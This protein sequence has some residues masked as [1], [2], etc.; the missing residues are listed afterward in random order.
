MDKLTVKDIVDFL[1]C[2]Y[3][4]DIST[5]IKGFSTSANSKSFCLTFLTEGY[6]LGVSF[7]AVILSKLDYIKKKY[8]HSFEDCW[9]EGFFFEIMIN[10]KKVYSSKG[11]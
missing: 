10:G 6:T 1:N 4:G 3:V 7:G 9:Y 11:D 8:I 5:E 2:D